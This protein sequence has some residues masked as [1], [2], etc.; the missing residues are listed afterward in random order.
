MISP[1]KRLV[2]LIL[3][4]F[5]VFVFT[6]ISDAGECQDCGSYVGFGYLYNA[7]GA[8]L[9]TDFRLSLT[10][11]EDGRLQMELLFLEDQPAR[12]IN[13]ER[14][15]PGFLAIREDVNTGGKEKAFAKGH[16]SIKAD[17]KAAGTI[18]VS[19]SDGKGGRIPVRTMKFFVEKLVA[20]NPESETSKSDTPTKDR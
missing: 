3:V 16:I 7:A 10:E 8:G 6:E 9:K 4:L 14:T 15:G 5:T 13:V 20:T 1:T 12:F 17:G 11:S 18:E 2:F 19:T